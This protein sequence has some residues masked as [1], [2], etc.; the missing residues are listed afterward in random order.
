MKKALILDR[1]GTLIEDKNY[2]NN[3][4]KIKFLKNNI[5]GLR[6]LSKNNYSFFIVSNQSGIARKLI[7]NEE[8][9]K[10]NYEIKKQL[11]KKKL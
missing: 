11:L 4:K 2:L 1:D 9:A 7:K 8:L 3:Y 6:N 10:I 5:R